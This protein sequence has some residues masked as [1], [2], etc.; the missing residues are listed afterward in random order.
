MGIWGFWKKLKSFNHNNHHHHQSSQMVRGN[1]FK[2]RV[3]C[4]ID[5]K[6]M[7]KYFRDKRVYIKTLEITEP[8]MFGGR[9]WEFNTR[10]DLITIIRLMNEVEDCHVA[11]ETVRFAV[12]Y[13]GEREEIPL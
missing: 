2:C 8:D 5:I 1:V 9:E 11:A 3:E 13:T 10:T 6:K 4:L 12:E 7:K